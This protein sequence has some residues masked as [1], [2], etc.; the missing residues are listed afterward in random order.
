MRRFEIEVAKPWRV[1]PMDQEMMPIGSIVGAIEVEEGIP[2]SESPR[3]LTDGLIT[4]QFRVAPEVEPEA[5]P[6]PSP[7]VV[8]KKPERPKTVTPS[9][10]DE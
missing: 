2:G 5:S 1:G 4:G 6:K 7:K 10:I 3:I 9:V 8:G